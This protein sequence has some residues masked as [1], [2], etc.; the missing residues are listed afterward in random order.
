MI[1]TTYISFVYYLYIM[2]HSILSGTPP[3]GPMGIFGGGDFTFWDNFVL[4]VLND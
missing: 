3:T 4:N 2:D 1:Y